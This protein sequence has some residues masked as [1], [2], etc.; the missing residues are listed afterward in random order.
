MVRSTCSTWTKTGGEAVP[1]KNKGAVASSEDEGGA[2]AKE[3]RPPLEAKRCK[4]HRPP[5]GPS[6]DDTM[7]FI[8]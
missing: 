2:M 5:E 8:P 7:I 6:P 1:P 4:E 3:C